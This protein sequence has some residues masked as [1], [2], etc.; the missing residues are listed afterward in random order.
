[1]TKPDPFCEWCERW[2]KRLWRIFVLTS[3]ALALAG[4]TIVAVHHLLV[5]AG[6]AAKA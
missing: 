2:E 1:M 5:L 4:A 6:V 3:T